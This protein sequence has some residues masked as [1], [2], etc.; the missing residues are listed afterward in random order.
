[1]RGREQGN[2]GGGR[3]EM[4]WREERNEGE[5]SGRGRKGERGQGGRGGNHSYSMHFISHQTSHIS[6]SV[7]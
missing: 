5:E 1:M 4:R 6:H 2:E 3:G 7:I